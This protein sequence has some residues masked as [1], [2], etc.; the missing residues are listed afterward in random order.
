MQY[1][2]PGEAS[3]LAG[4]VRDMPQLDGQSLP[5]VS[6]RG[7][8]VGSDSGETRNRILRSARKVINERGYHAA[9]FQAIAVAANLSRPTLHY[10]FGSREEIYGALVA[11]AG[12]VLADCIGEAKGKNTLLEQLTA[13]VVAMHEA[14]LRDRSQVAFLVSACLE[15]TRNPGL[16]VEACD[17]LRNFLRSSLGE[18][19]SR[20]E[21]SADAVVTPIADLLHAMLWGVGFH[22]GFVGSQADMRLITKQ[23]MRLLSHGLLGPAPVAVSV[24][25]TKKF[26]V[27]AAD[28]GL[29][30]RGEGGVLDMTAGP[31]QKTS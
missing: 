30:P 24:E 11:E 12:G 5:A 7:R 13:L 31:F 28:C 8:P 16:Q 27:S 3:F 26:A 20:G 23:L 19:K 4:G 9:T 1:G 6:R 14:D 18:A 10:Y 17:V 15:S 2:L 21:L 29:P 25:P 22:A